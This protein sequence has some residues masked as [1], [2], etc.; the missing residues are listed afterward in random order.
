MV[1]IFGIVNNIDCLEQSFIFLRHS[2]FLPQSK[3]MHNCSLGVNV[4]VWDFCPKVV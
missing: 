3:S 2:S 4:S 1:G